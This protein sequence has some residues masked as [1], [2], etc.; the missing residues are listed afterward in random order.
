MMSAL[1]YHPAAPYSAGITVLLDVLIKDIDGQT[2]EL[3][4]IFKD[5]K[6]K[7]RKVGCVIRQFGGNSYFTYEDANRVNLELMLIAALIMPKT[8]IH[9][10]QD[11]GGGASWH[12]Y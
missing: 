10:S 11:S 6:T 5:A 9:V 4:R 8:D 2:D 7:K 3:T 12:K 1:F